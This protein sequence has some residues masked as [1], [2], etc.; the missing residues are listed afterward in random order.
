MHD[1][2]RAFRAKELSNQTNLRKIFKNYRSED[3]L[4]IPNHQWNLLTEHIEK[5]TDLRIN[6]KN[7]LLTPIE[8][9]VVCFSTIYSYKEIEYMLIMSRGTI[10]TYESRAKEKL[11]AINKQ[12][13]ACLA[14]KHNV[15]N[16]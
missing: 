14:I 5:H 6:L 9:I 10:K 7:K 8:S 16:L 11:N 13:T 3:K 2:I 15:F 1:L 12:H 4:V